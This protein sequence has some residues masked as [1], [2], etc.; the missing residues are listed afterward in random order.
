MSPSLIGWPLSAAS[1]SEASSG[2]P[3]NVTS[4]PS[5][6]SRISALVYSRFTVPLVP[7]TETRRVFDC[8]QAG[9]IAGTVPTKGRE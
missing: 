1:A 9:L 2:E 4:Q 6:K 5:P 7:S 8:A 3:T